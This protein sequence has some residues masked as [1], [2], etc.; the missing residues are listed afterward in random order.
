MNKC[1][2][3]L[4]EVYEEILEKAYP[5]ATPSQLEKVAQGL[6]D[7]VRQEGHIRDEAD[8]EQVT[9]ELDAVLDAAKAAEEPDT[10]SAGTATAQP[11]PPAPPKSTYR[12]E[13]RVA[14]Q[15]IEPN[16]SWS[17]DRLS[18]EDTTEL[19][20][21]NFHQIAELLQRFHDLSQSAASEL[22]GSR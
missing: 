21:L 6:I 13:V 5:G 8:A 3:P 9:K 12:V 11:T 1:V 20:S 7:H 2:D 15:R 17:S 22:G 14:L 19:G 16:G 4:L 10:S 18:F